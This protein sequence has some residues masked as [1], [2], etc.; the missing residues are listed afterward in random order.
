MQATTIKIEDPLLRELK[1]ITPKKFSLSKFVKEI[2]E[3]EV[4]RHKMIIAAEKYNEFLAS[5]PEESSWLQDWEAADLTSTP[6]TKRKK[7]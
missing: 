7:S 2:L 6:K 5:N 1:N 4:Q 3:Q